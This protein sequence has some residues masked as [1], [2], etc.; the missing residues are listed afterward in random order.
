MSVRDTQYV[1]FVPR[2]YKLNV[3]KLILDR[4]TGFSQKK[5]LTS[6]P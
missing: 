1:R 4:R 2:V 5:Q 3:N 6:V